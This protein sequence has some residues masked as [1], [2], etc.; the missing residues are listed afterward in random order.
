[1]ELDGALTAYFGLADEYCD[2]GGSLPLTGRGGSS[3]SPQAGALTLLAESLD[4]VLVTVTRLVPFEYVDPPDAAE[5]FDSTE[6]LLISCSAGRRVDKEGGG[7]EGCRV[8]SG[9]GVGLAGFV[10]FAVGRVMMGGGSSP[11]CLSPFGWLPIVE[12]AIE[13]F[14][15]SGGLLTDLFRMTTGLLVGT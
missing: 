4:F 13:P 7:R 1:M 10:P 14:T 9:G 6:S 3:A 12:S 5:E 8:G 15:C 11:L 2:F